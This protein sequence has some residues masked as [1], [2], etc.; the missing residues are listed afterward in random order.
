M[1]VKYSSL[2]SYELGQAAWC[3]SPQKI[4]WT[5]YIVIANISN[6]GTI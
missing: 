1:T 5:D 6:I 3:P 4:S 2:E